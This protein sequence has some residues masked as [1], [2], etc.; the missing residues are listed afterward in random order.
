MYKTSNTF[1]TLTIVLFLASCS[2][3]N[4][5]ATEKEVTEEVAEVEEAAAE[6]EMQAVCVWDNIAVR[7]DPSAKG[8]YI[9][10]I[11]VGESLFYL[12][13]DSVGGER[14]YAK[15]RLNDGQEGW[16]L[17]DFIIENA[18]PSV[19]L[20]DISL[21]SRPDLLTKTDKE[22]K[23]MDIIASIEVQDDW[24]KI[25]GK[26][27]GAKWMDEGWVKADNISLTPVDIATAKFASKALSIADDGERA[28]A[29]TE[30]VNNTDLSGSSFIGYLNSIL[31]ELTSPVEE[32]LSDSTSSTVEEMASDSIN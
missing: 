24:M 9:T 1:S 15:I 22:F 18:K 28:E 26:R 29:I 25:K 19:V 30:I 5:T 12:N 16:A 20:S 21:Y 11:S 14:T 23:M 4:Q 32:V 2:S 3:S 27:S 31:S 7:K 13:K 8:K 17:R 10:A 6:M